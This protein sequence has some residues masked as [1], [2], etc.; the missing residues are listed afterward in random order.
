MSRRLDRPIGRHGADRIAAADDAAALHA[1]AGEVA[2]KALR[3]VVAPAGRIHA[4]RAAELG[5][6]AHQRRVQ[7]AAL[8]E[9]FDQRAVRL[10]VHRRDDVLHAFDRRE[11]LRA[12]DVPGDFVEHGE[13]RVDR[14]EPHARLDQPP[15]QQAALAEAVHAVAL[16]D[17]GRLLGQ[18]ERLARLL[19]RHQ[20]ERGLE[21]FVH[22]LGVLAGFEILD[23][24]IDDL[25]QLPPPLEPRRRRSPPAAA[26]R[27]P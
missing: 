17:A 27:A 24:R 15:R 11:R 16:A 8:V 10:V 5:Q 19:A 1:A 13:E 22:Q 2:R 3:P 21:V 9:V 12:V 7:H 14:D 18:V 26:S 23:G 25:A 6:V 20:A 4:R